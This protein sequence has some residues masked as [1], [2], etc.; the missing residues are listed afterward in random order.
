MIK[1]DIN[2]LNI[3]E[4]RAAIVDA[5]NIAVNIF[6]SHIEK[7]FDDVITKGLKSIADAVKLDRVSIYRKTIIDD[8]TKFCEIYRWDK[9][10]EGL[11]FLEQKLRILPII[12]VIEKWLVTLLKDECVKIKKTDMSEDES[13]F[14]TEFRIKSILIVPIF[15]YGDFW[16]AVA[17]QDHT[18]DNYFDEGCFDLLLSAARLFANAIIRAEMSDNVNRAVEALER[19]EK[20]A[21]MLNKMAVTF[22]SECKESFEA[23]MTDGVRL[24]ADMIKLDRLSVW[25]NLEKPDGLHASQIYRWDRESGGTTVPTAILSDVAYSQLAPSWEFILKSG[26]SINSPARLLPKQEAE[27][28]KMFGVVSVF[29]S[30]V[31]LNN[32]FW[33]F[34]LFE[35]REGEHFFEEDQT[36][37]MRSAAFLCTNTVMRTDM[38]RKIASVNEFNRAIINASR[39]GFIAFD[40]DLCVVDVNDANLELF[41]CDKQYYI[42]HFY[43]FSPEY[44]PNGDKSYEKM[45]ETSKRALNGEQITVEWTH[46]TCRGELVPFEITLTRT[47]YKGKYLLL[48]YQYDLRNLK[49][50]TEELKNQSKQLKDRLDQQELLSDISRSFITSGDTHTLVNEAIA[51]LGNYYK[52]SRVVIFKQDFQSDNAAVSYIWTS[53]YNTPRR[54][55]FNP[56]KIVKASFPERL[57]NSATVPILS[58][59][60]TTISKI[61]DFRALLLDSVNAFICAPLYVEGLLW[62]LLAV[63]QCKVS[64]YWTDIEKSFIAM[65][66]STIAGAI[67]LDIYNTK[68]KD[69]VTKVTAASKAKSEFLSN[70]SHEMRTPMN[71]IINMTLIAKNTESLERKN[72]ALDK[73]GDASTHLLGVINDILDMSK[74]EANKFELFP[75]RF[76]FEKML[77]RVVNVI[78]F[79]VEE[80]HQ[81]LN[82]QI[83]KDIPKFLICDDQRLSQIIA[84][85]LS[86]AVKFTPENGLINLD[87]LLV[88]EKKGVCTLQISV[89]DTGIGISKEHQAH[90][91]QAFQQ[92][93]TSTART[94]G[95]TGLGLSISKKFVEMMGGVIWVESETGNGSTFTFTVKVKRGEDD[96]EKD[97]EK[98]IIKTSDFSGHRV[99]LVEDMEINREIVLMLLEETN[100]E[101]DCAAD[102]LQAVEMFVEEPERYEMILMD[103][104]MPGMDGYEATNQIRLIEEK[105][106]ERSSY[107]KRV[108][109]IAM[110]ANVFKEDIDHCIASGMDDHVGKPLDFEILMEKLRY[111]IHSKE[112]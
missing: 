91:F 69:A 48:S 56:G 17:L 87:T 104:H 96:E 42:E 54:D 80:K 82:V 2:N 103:V 77:H 100:L 90:L 13:A 112:S 61:D 110:T 68:L 34:V 107:K 11:V 22:L 47:K 59:P 7:E 40:E 43:E 20:M 30:P 92:A 95:G 98:D 53:D 88:K 93:E 78:T 85:L 111:Y 27:M 4:R 3:S 15:S 45:L 46:R 70:M 25:R 79:R 83:D 94:Y 37:I 97:H 16:G 64:R 52:V 58:C 44:Q 89:K 71:A 109:I 6:T 66:A 28:L 23:M 106:K 9:A 86:N 102:G 14:L 84:N 36:E 60:D 101:I 49:K 62:G 76:N 50:I 75:V 63:E 51:K 99:L 72:Y 12:P 41:G 39:I 108:P 105:L 8:E 65:T 57:Y 18:N 81:S 26:E 67:M 21:N 24:I 32:A 55:N 35:D 5:L 74:I 1:D 29:V 31:F 73:I 38:E 19:R 33:G 10:K